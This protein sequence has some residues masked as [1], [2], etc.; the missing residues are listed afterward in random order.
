MT[1]ACR[2]LPGPTTPRDSCCTTSSS[3]K[4]EPGIPP[5]NAL[6]IATLN[7]AKVLKQDRDLGSIAPGKLADLLLVEGNPVAD[8]SDIRRGRLVMKGGVIYS[9]ADVYAAAGIQAA[10]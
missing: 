3:S 7:A 5:A 10:R 8:I 1:S 6:Q 9:S 2:S 4:C